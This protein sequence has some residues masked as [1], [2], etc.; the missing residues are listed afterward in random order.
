MVVMES[1]YYCLR[2]HAGIF[3]GDERMGGARRMD[4]VPQEAV[5]PPRYEC[6]SLSHPPLL[7]NAPFEV[8]LKNMAP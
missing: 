4:A 2:P 3:L 7:S 5:V 1:P 6:S 8:E